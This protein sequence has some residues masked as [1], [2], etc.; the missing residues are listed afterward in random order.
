L[1]T[2]ANL[3]AGEIT[4]KGYINQRQSLTLRAD[5]VA[6]LYVDQPDPAVILLA[7]VKRE[8]SH[9]S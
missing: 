2:S 6:R 9:A 1:G 4:D 5:Q 3:D 8:F 7:E